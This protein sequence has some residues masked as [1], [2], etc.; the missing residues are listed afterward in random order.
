MIIGSRN[1]IARQIPSQPQL[2]EALAWLAGAWESLP[3][4]GRIEIGRGGVYALVQ[5]YDTKVC[6]DGPAFEAHRKY[7]DIQAV[8][9]GREIMGWAPL[10]AVM[11]NREYQAE[12]DVLFGTVAAAT[13]TLVPFAAGQVMVLYPWDAHAP[14]LAAGTPAPVRK[15]VIK[16]PAV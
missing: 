10:D 14:G 2:Q 3:E 15:I 6:G 11:V 8:V 1:E 13:Q 16:V 9:Q 7:I 5:S 4:D 12:K